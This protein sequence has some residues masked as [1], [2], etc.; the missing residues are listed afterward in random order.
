MLQLSVL[1]QAPISEGSTAAAALRNSVDLARWTEE[2]G[3]V[4]VGSPSTVR[5]RIEQAAEEYGA[6]EMMILTITHSHEDRRRSYELIAKE[7][8]R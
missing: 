4:I 2:L 1:D 7:F 3:Y 6:D 5:K 8:A